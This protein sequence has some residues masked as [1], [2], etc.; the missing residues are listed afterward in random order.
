VAP[1]V[2]TH[3]LRLSTLRLG[4]A[5]PVGGRP[6]ASPPAPAPALPEAAP[7]VAEGVA[8][9]VRAR[10]AFAGAGADPPE[11]PA[12]RD[13]ATLEAQAARA[14]ARV[15]AQG[16]LPY[17]AAGGA[18]APLAP[19]LR[20][21]V[22]RRLGFDFGAVRVSSD[23]DADRRARAHG[24]WAIAEGCNLSFARGAFAPHTLVGAERLAHELA[25]VVQAAGGA[26]GVF[27]DPRPALDLGHAS[28]VV[29]LEGLEVTPPAGSRFPPGSRIR[30]RL[31]WVIGRLT[32]AAPDELVERAFRHLD[33][34]LAGGLMLD[35]ARDSTAERDEPGAA[36]TV[37]PGVALALIAWLTAQGRTVTLSTERLQIL[38][39]AEVAQRAWQLWAGIRGN[40]DPGWYSRSIFLSQVSRHGA[41]L[42]RFGA[43]YQAYSASGTPAN[44]N[45]AWAALNDLLSEVRRPMQALEAIRADAALT[46]E[47]GYRVL[48]A[49]GAPSPNLA[50]LFL[51]YADTQP[52][53]VQAALTGTPGRRALLANFVSY[54]QFG[55]VGRTGND[56]SLSRRPGRVNMPPLDA[57][58][59]VV[60]QLLAPFRAGSGGEYTFSVHLQFHDVFEAFASYAYRWEVVRVPA[61]ATRVD[62]ATAPGARPDDWDL[63]RERLSRAGR[64]SQADL[65]RLRRTLGPPGVGLGSLVQANAV[66]RYGGAVLRTALE[67]LTRPRSEQ[68]VVFSA[69]G[70]YI[71]RVRAVPVRR[72]G[73]F[74]RGASVAYMPVFVEDM[75][76]LASRDVTAQLVEDQRIAAR[77]AELRRRLSAQ[78]SFPGR[79]A[80]EQELRE[81]EAAVGGVGSILAVQLEAAT[82][83]R[84]GLPDASPEARRL[85]R[86]IEQLRQRLRMRSERFGHGAPL[87]A[88]LFGTFVSDTGSTVRLLLEVAWLGGD[89]YLV[90][91]VTT[92]NSSMAHGSGVRVTAILGAVREILE[93]HSGY[94]RGFATVVLD[95][96]AHRLRI[97]AS[98][99]SILSEAVENLATVA[100]IAA[101]AAAPLTGGSSLS[102]LVPI[103]I[104]GAV[105]AG[106]RLVQRSIDRTLRFDLATAMDVVNVVGSVIGLAQ[107]ATPLRMVRLGRAFMIM[108]MGLDGTNMLLM[109]AGMVEQI[110]QLEGLPPGLRRARLLEVLG[111]GMLNVGIS[112]GGALAHR[113]VEA[114]RG[115]ART[116]EGPAAPASERLQRMR[117][118]L[119][120]ELHDVHIVESQNLQGNAVR[121][122]YEGGRFVLMVGPTARSARVAGHVNTMLFLRRFAGVGGA[123]RRLLDLALTKL[124]LHPGHGTA[125]FEARAEVTKLRGI[126]EHLEALH[127]QVVDRVS[128]L[129][130]DPELA[131]AAIRREIAALEAQVRAHQAN[132]DSFQPGRG[133]I[134]SQDTSGAHPSPAAPAQGAHPQVELPLAQAVAQANAIQAPAE[135]LAALRRLREGRETQ[136]A[137][138]EAQ[139]QVVRRRLEGLAAAQEALRIA[140]GPEGRER[141][142]VR[143]PELERSRASLEAQRGRLE[144]E[145]ALLGSEVR[146]ITGHETRANLV[147]NPVEHARLP[148]FPP[149]TLVAT[150]AGPRPIEALEVGS[151]VLA[152]CAA[153]AAARPRR[154]EALHRGVT[155][156][157]VELKVG[158]QRLRATREHPFLVAGGRGFVPA[159]R[160]APG[161]RLQTLGGA[162]AE[163]QEVLH[164]SLAAPAPTCNL[165]V[166]EDETFGVGPG[167]VVHNT[168]VADLQ[169]GAFILYIGRN[170]AFPG[171]VYVGITEPPLRGGSGSR[172]YG[173]HQQAAREVRALRALRARQGD[174]LSA[175]DQRRLQV[176]EFREGMILEPHI[177]GIK[178]RD[179]ARYIEH[180]NIGFARTEY[181]VDNVMNLRIE[182]VSTTPKRQPDGSRL[183]ELQLLVRAIRA[184]PDVQRAGLCP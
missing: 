43:A 57:R 135:R 49:S 2:H 10:R 103:G 22:G 71:V 150:P 16:P 157:W 172:E 134:E 165:S 25:H 46:N 87:T 146:T 147:A 4:P 66:L 92:P 148:C 137:G 122:Q 127:Q 113:A 81:L 44:V 42:E 19:A 178:N 72:D 39:A 38:R 114:R 12:G 184:D 166:A 182:E 47:V 160:L 34:T 158:D 164:I 107:V 56:Q 91:D 101:I 40:A 126:I 11:D 163:V 102:L 88:R 139:L 121:V 14:A 15:A 144:A 13:R 24:A 7:E 100:S 50:A 69:P 175:E 67:Q 96:Q 123:I 106:Y 124:R 59:E 37:R 161:D 78:S 48:F 180:Q 35:D 3:R 183:S 120:P 125:G 36:I 17:M 79:P 75:A 116:P 73:A 111:Q 112:V 99:G 129:G 93:G 176:F 28:L 105:P 108:G 60:P 136:R 5:A 8:P 98:L 23:A 132:V 1:E 68:T 32:G 64:Y 41:A 168:P 80:L 18:S 119:P 171:M 52:E 90:S 26:R 140:P 167:L 133:F 155:L 156:A 149:G 177:V 141:R 86:E 143:G 77:I 6:A 74:L 169:M 29:T 174:R 20:D 152:W 154:V 54:A 76:G 153:E 142:R 45:T 179:H 159:H 128:A 63:L 94:G 97:E 89:R 70:T 30:A 51:G 85:D 9:A 115:A 84:R 130:G 27:T 117:E 104:V 21:E 31:A 162:T 65:E 53:Q 118:V 138:V 181:G 33:A 109:G 82:Q 58:M 83:R 151:E 131:G 170:P 61:S 62:A 95:G 173:H 110:E 145:S 55:L